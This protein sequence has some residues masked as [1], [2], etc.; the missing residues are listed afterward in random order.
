M[1]E[2]IQLTIDLELVSGVMK[3]EI[4]SGN[5]NVEH[6]DLADNGVGET[7]QLSERPTATE[8][9][10]FLLIIFVLWLHREIHV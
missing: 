2:V 1:Y 6:S 5:D 7:Q 9:E 3:S 10:Q 4:G 8:L